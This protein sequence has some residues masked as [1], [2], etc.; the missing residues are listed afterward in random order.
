MMMMMHVAWRGRQSMTHVSVHACRNPWLARC[1]RPWVAALASVLGSAAS[2]Y[3]W[4]HDE[5][6]PVALEMAERLPIVEELLIRQV[7]L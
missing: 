3:A 5:V 4:V 6:V 2:A 1:A 7:S